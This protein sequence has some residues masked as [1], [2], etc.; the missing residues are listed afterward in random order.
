[1]DPN[2]EIERIRQI[3]YSTKQ[4]A[5]DL[6]P[7]SILF[8]KSVPVWK[9]ALDLLVASVGLLALSPIMLAAAIAVKTT[10]RGPILFRQLRE[11]KDGR[12]FVIYKF[13]SMENGAESKQS[14]LRE[15]NQ[16]IGPAF[17]MDNDPRVTKVGK[18]LR[19]SCVDELPQLFNVL[20]GE[21]SMVGPRPL[22]VTESQACLQWQRRRLDVL[23]GMT[24]IWQVRKAEEVTFDEWMRMD[25][26]YIQ[27]SNLLFDI[28][29]LFQTVRVAALQ[30]GSM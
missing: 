14:E 30:R 24:C 20:K 23:P 29:L 4:V 5:I 22:P 12:Q 1:M 25:L 16:R 21:M 26:N 17:K 2:S 8:V 13:R 15:Q 9:R 27:R 6:V 18:W 10:S 28:G 19:K 3:G 7:S 11:G